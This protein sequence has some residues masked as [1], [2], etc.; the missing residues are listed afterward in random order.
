MDLQSAGGWRTDMKRD[1][2]VKWKVWELIALLLLVA[3][4]AVAAVKLFGITLEY[5]R[6][7][8]AYEEL[9]SYVLI[10]EESDG[11]T[12]TVVT[13]SAGEDD[14]EDDMVYY[15]SCP[16]VNFSSLWSVN[17]EVVGWIYASGTT[18]NYP[19]VQASD[20]EY[21]LTHLV[22]GQTNTSGSIFMDC[23]N[24]SDFSNS[25]TIIY[26]H[27]MKNGTMFASLVNYDNQSYY[28][29]HPVM[30]LVT[31]QA[32]YLVEIFAGFVTSVDSDVW[33]LE[34]ASSAD[35]Q[36]W[37]DMVEASSLFN[38]DVT[39]SVNDHIITLATCS[40]NYE[41]ARFVVMGV[42]REQ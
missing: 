32:S 40:Y 33:Q 2:K 39:P 22:N 27:H 12:Q 4:A 17:S 5:S 19:V 7:K 1:T 29:S 34:F 26:G 15:G 41:N 3:I 9:T 11:N 31:P 18:I 8:S 24:K 35:Y 14:A 38:S 20:N 30:W 13:V 36:S 23:L 16:Q 37:I 28:N 6:G 10:P 25:N 42:L 21:Y